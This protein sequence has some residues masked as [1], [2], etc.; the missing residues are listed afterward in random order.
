MLQKR[1]ALFKAGSFTKHFHNASTFCGENHAAADWLILQSN[2]FW[3]YMSKGKFA[4][5]RDTRNSLIACYASCCCC[6][7]NSSMKDEAVSS[8]GLVVPG[9]SARVDPITG[10]GIYNSSELFVDE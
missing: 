1:V 7:L 5:G 10:G 3:A 4:A 9:A 6:L 2:V 8:D